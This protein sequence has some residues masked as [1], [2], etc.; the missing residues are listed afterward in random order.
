MTRKEEESIETT[1]K[2]KK[3]KK[4]SWVRELAHLAHESFLQAV[5]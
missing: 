1:K 2:K 3:K 5:I 4:K